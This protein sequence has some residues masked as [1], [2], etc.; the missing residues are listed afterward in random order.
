[1]KCDS[2]GNLINHSSEEDGIKRSAKACYI[3]KTFDPQTADEL[4]E[5]LKD[6]NN[7][8]SKWIWHI[9][10]PM[11]FNDKQLVDYCKKIKISNSAWLNYCVTKLDMIDL[12]ADMSKLSPALSKKYGGEKW[13][14]LVRELETGS[15]NEGY[16]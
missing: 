16:R 10:Y 6:N 14:N 15:I 9:S 8:A 13:H 5:I 7:Y 12:G 2:F 4:K 11:F 3:I 1:M